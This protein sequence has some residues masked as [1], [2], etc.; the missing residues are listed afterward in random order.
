MYEHLEQMSPFY[1]SERLT[2]LAIELIEKSSALEGRVASRTARSIAELML[3]A[4][5]YY[6]NLIEGQHTRPLEVEANLRNP[7]KTKNELVELGT[8]HI[9]T[10]QAA[11]DKAENGESPYDLHFILWLHKHFYDR[12]P[13]SMK[14]VKGEK[15]TGNVIP[16]EWRQED[17]EVGQHVAPKYQAIPELMKEFVELYRPVN[18]KAV[19]LTRIAAAHHRFVW[20]HPFLDG[21]GRVG[22]LLTHAWLR[23]AGVMGTG[24]WSISRGL[25]RNREAYLAR[26]QNADQPRQGDLD[27]RG[28]LSL[29]A[30]DEFCEFVL[31][32][33]IDQVEYMRDSFGLHTLEHR[34]QRA[35]AEFA[36]SIPGIREEGWRL[37]KEAIN[38]GEFERGDA[39]RITGLGERVARDLLSSLIDHALLVSDSPRGRKV[40]ATFPVRAVSWYF[41]ELF[42]PGDVLEYSKGLDIDSKQSAAHKIPIAR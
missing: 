24:L 9:R 16:G 4:N 26:L 22:R 1:P 21:N 27:G 29:R 13:D 38:Q 14:V 2:D 32:T 40:Y 15:K 23:A 31:K 28:N 34:L 7:A 37:V 10:E 20:I 42:P 18:N 33:A 3:H 6:S 30:L 25:A 11:R 39:S 12:L 19:T 41:P 35:F 5:S 36:I 17:V 8:A